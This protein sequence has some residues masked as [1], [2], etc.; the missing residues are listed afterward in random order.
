[1]SA[2]MI[3]KQTA[4]GTTAVF[5]GD[6]SI[7]SAKEL[8]GFF[9]ELGPIEADILLDHPSALDLC[10]WQMVIARKRSGKNSKIQANLNEADQ[11][12][13]IRTGMRLLIHT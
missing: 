9:Q 12:L 7:R 5:T 1:M 2:Q 8:L 13:L 4:D 11:Q 3:L 6:L 10:F